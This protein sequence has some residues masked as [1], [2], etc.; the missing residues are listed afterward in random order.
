MK[1][2]WFWIDSKKFDIAIAKW[3]FVIG[4]KYSHE[5]EYNEKDGTTYCKHCYINENLCESIFENC[6]RKV[7]LIKICL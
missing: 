5:Y 2:G 7:I 1:Y 3:N 4:I 6:H